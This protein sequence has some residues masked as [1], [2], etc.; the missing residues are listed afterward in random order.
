[1][2]S[3]TGPRWRTVSRRNVAIP[4]SASSVRRLP[5]GASGA[6]D[7]LDA[8]DALG[9]PSNASSAA[10]SSTPAEISSPLGLIAP[11][12]FI[13]IGVATSATAATV[14][15][16][17]R[18]AAHTAAPRSSALSR[19]DTRRPRRIPVSSGRSRIGIPTGR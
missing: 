12:R 5:S 4:A 16:L 11:A 18:T 7:A 10:N 6:L 15:R 14:R 3:S 8:L 17:T 13:T 1:M 19:A 2:T 9:A